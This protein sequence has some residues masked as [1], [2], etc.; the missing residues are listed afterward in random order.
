MP[1]E[2]SGQKM[3]FPPFRLFKEYI[4]NELSLGKWEDLKQLFRDSSSQLCVCVHIKIYIKMVKVLKVN[5]YEEL[6][7]LIPG[8]PPTVACHSE[9]LIKSGVIYRLLFKSIG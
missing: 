9:E 1:E 8:A 4:T 3:G 5:V 7:R 6:Q 2:K